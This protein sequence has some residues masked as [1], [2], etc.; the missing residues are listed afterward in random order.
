MQSAPSGPQP[1][2]IRRLSML[3]LGIALTAVAAA[4][5]VLMVVA[6]LSSSR[7]TAM[8]V[9]PHK[10][11]AAIGAASPAPLAPATATRRL[12]FDDR[13]DGSVLVRD[14]DDA[15]HT[16]VIAPGSDGFLRATVRTFARERKRS[17]LTA[18]QPFVLSAHADG[19]LSLFDPSTQRRVEL[20]AFGPTNIERFARLLRSE[21]AQANMHETTASSG[22]SPDTTTR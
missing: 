15:K 8:A 7:V 1:R 22:A 3:G 2:T 20:S 13:A 9:S 4:A 6:T 5:A 14:H 11:V 12:H 16:V 10:A 21:T 19:R 17:H 18:E